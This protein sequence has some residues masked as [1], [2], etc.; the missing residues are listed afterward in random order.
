MA[1]N[2]S[3]TAKGQGRAD[4]IRFKARQER[5]NLRLVDCLSSNRSYGYRLAGGGHSSPIQAC[6]VLVVFVVV[7]F[8][9]MEAYAV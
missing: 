9:V 7:I 5:I 3:T 2:V 4:P 6:G 8:V 1:C